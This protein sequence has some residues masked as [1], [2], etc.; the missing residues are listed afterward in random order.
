MRSS[1]GAFLLA[2][3]SR[4][5]RGSRG[6]RGPSPSVKTLRAEGIAPPTPRASARG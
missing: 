5:R 4:G 3:E 6:H 1:M 2:L